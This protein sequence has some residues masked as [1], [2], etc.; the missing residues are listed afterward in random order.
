MALGGGA[1]APRLFPQINASQ[2]VTYV[3][4]MSQRGDISSCLVVGVLRKEREV[5]GTR[6]A[7]EESTLGLTVRCEECGGYAFLSR[8]APEAFKRE[9]SEIWTYECVDSS[10]R[11]SGL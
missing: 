11:H 4:A 3:T 8:C 5:I 7:S 6:Y 1:T 9:G 10:I 2:P